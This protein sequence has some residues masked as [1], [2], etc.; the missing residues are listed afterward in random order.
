[1]F[2]KILITA[3]FLLLPALALYLCKKYKFFGKLGPVLLLYIIGLLIGNIGV[4]PGLAL[5]SGTKD[6]QQL[7]STVTIP[8]A[9]PLLLFGCSFQRSDTRDQLLAMITGFVSVVLVVSLGYVLF[10]HKIDSAANANDSAAKI[11]GILT[12]SYTGGTVNMASLKKLLGVSDESY[13]LMNGYDM[14]FVFVYLTCLISFGIKLCRRI[15]PNTTS[16]DDNISVEEE[17][18]YKGLA[19]KKGLISLAELL[20]VVAI[21]VGSSYGLARFFE[22]YLSLQF[23]T[24]FILALTTIS[25]GASFIPW[26]RK[27]PYAEAVGMYCIYIFS[28]VVAS[29]ADVSQMDFM[30]NM[31]LLGYVALMI[32]GSLLLQVLFARLFHIDSD[33]T[34]I[35]SVALIASPPFVP[36]I[37]AAM[38]N[39]RVLLTG[40]SIG[41]VGYAVG[42]YLGYGMS[43]L[44]P[45]LFP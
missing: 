3:A 36:M 10:A 30:G 16:H 29:M 7:L 24:V 37:A 12:G 35:S 45:I 27:I 22:M 6:I 11:A 42:T 25:L 41:I 38:H 13:L 40:I 26:V 5:P 15:L 34:V 33:T 21:I 19:S 9:I 14:I 28:L 20:G 17:D 8:I 4:I 43:R 2:G 32:F 44:L 39:K 31:P 1:M 18:P 23:M